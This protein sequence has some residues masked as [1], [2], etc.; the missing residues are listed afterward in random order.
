MV[1][2]GLAP[3]LAACGTAP[4]GGSPKSMRV[5][6]ANPDG[7]DLRVCTEVDGHAL[8]VAIPGR[9][10]SWS[11]TLYAGKY[12]LSCQEG[13]LCALPLLPSAL[14]APELRVQ[15]APV[16]PSSATWACIPAGPAL[17]GDEL[18]V[19]QEDER[20]ARVVTAATFWIAR[21]EVTNAEY[22]R[23]L[24][25]CGREPDP[26]W[27]AFD[28]KK[29]LIARDAGSARFTTSAANL[30]V[31]TVSLAGA[32]AY[33]D[34]LTRTTRVAHR[35]PSEIEWEKAARGPGS[36]VYAF[37]NVYRLHAANA[38]SGALTEVATHPANGWGLFDM[39]GNAFEW[40]ADRYASGPDQV[41]RGG[42]FV[43]DGMYLRNSFRMRTR[44]TTRADDFG[45]RPVREAAPMADRSPE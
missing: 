12:W 25:E 27:L 31:V 36:Q 14:G 5:V 11:A 1:A 8:V 28:S 17:I 22:A 38:E 6:V 32:L 44:P 23:F 33:C 7:L 2:L 26:G 39:T 37:G 18:G 15:V 24:N 9:A 42:S 3:L 45:F 16:A 10:P 13:P 19:G 30:P 4:I 34:W 21:T 41:L 43:L 35:L 29:C 20:P 40:V